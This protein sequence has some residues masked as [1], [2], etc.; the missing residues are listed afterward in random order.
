MKKA[1]GSPQPFGAV[2][3]GNRVNFAVQVPQGKSCELLLYRAGRTS[4]EQCFEM[5]EEE[6]IGEVR[7]LAVEDIDADK[8]EYNYRIGRKI[9]VDP[10]VREVAGKEHFGQKK[11]VQKH[12]VRGKLVSPE[13]DW[14]GDTRLHLPWNEVVAYSLHVRGFTKHT[15]SKAAHKGTFQGVI[16]KIPYLKELGVNQIQCMPVYEFEE[17]DSGHINYWGYG[18]GFYFAPKESYAA[19]KNASAELKDMVRACHAEKIEVVLEMPFQ[20]GI[21]VQTALECLRFYMLEYHIDGF[22]V[23]PYIIPWDIV[24]SDPFLKDIKIMRKDDGFQNVMR[25]FLKGDENMVNDV[26]WALK[27]NSSADGKCNYITG[28]TGFTLWDLVSYD[29]KHNE[30]NGERN[31]DGPDY[32]YSWN[33]GAEGPSRKKAVMAL[34]KSQVRNAFYLLLTAQGTPCL[35]AGDE[36]Y[37]TQKGNNNVYCQD[38]ETAWVNWSRLKTDDSLFRYVKAL[39]AFRKAHAC[40]HRREELNGMDRTACGMPDVSYHGENAWKVKA[41]VA[42]RQLGVL[43]AGV[44]PGDE[45]CFAAYNMH[46]ILHEYALPSPGKGKMWYL[47]ADTERGVLEKPELLVEQ[48]SI[49]LKE[50]SIALLVGREKAEVKNE[51]SKTFLHNHET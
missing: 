18:A 23:N 2:V 36:F 25:R 3:R 37:N 12:Q 19:G 30:A 34:R 20:A 44:E 27:H 22:V 41:E 42:S 4:P 7:F 39:I 1:K 9:C 16:E 28:H 49:E 48:K 38:N 35:L 26:I 43:Y 32:N 13:Y 47:A 21:S 14:E 40:L 31:T 45:P 29:G 10:Y 24:S 33:C 17:C 6:G 11:D 8:Y 50:R 5:P 51:S 15:S 46:W